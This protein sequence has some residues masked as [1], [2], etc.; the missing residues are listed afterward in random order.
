M[1]IVI[2]ND[3]SK[4]HCGSMEVVNMIK[5][6]YNNSDDDIRIIGT[7]ERSMLQY[8]IDNL[9]NPMIGLLNK[10]DLYLVNGEGAFHDDSKIIENIGKIMKIGKENN[11]KAILFNSVWQN[12]KKMKEWL[13]YFD[14]IYVRESSS[15]NELLNDGY[16]S[17]I[18]PDITCL[19]NTHEIEK[20][21]NVAFGYD[22]MNESLRNGI[23][24][25]CDQYDSMNIFKYKDF[26]KFVKD[27]AKYKVIVSGRHHT[28]IAACKARTKCLPIEGNSHKL[29]GL[30]NDSGAKI[31]IIKNISEFDKGMEY[32]MSDESDEEY[33]KL[34]V[35]LDSFNINDYY[36]VIEQ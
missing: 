29:V 16:E 34:F 7:I 31:P 4:Y 19:V 21:K 15:K 27:I 18:L 30:I 8:N 23:H 33:N 10:A 20:T 22:I 26:N 12:N 17:I 32:I 14:K 35:Y 2:L 1:K 25:K 6:V 28:F 24:D 5:K 13:N 36:K 9:I 11:K 3:C